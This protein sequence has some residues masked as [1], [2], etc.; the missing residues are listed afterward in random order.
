MK[1]FSK[2]PLESKPELIFKLLGL[3]FFLSYIA[4]A[5]ANL[6]HSKRDAM[7]FEHILLKK[8]IR[9]ND[10]GTQHPINLK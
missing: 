2:T 6:W 4:A 7:K 5:F 8:H 3:A 1:L 9:D 10:Q